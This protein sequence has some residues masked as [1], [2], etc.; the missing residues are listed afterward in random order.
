MATVALLGVGQF[1]YGAVGAFVGAVAGGI[2]DKALFFKSTTGDEDDAAEYDRGPRMM[3]VKQQ[4]SSYGLSIPDVFGTATVA[5]NIFWFGGVE[6]V[7][8]KDRQW[9]DTD[10]S[11]GKGGGGTDNP[12]DEEEGYWHRY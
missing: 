8:T 6:E 10:S 2:M 4:S 1:Y 11:G 3:D 7:I 12:F 9:V 5:G